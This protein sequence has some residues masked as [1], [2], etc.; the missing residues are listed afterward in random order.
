MVEATTEHIGLDMFGLD[1]LLTPKGKHF[2]LEVNSA[3]ILFQIT[4]RRLAKA[5]KRSIEN[6]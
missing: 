2:L 4:E 6:A 3:P 1:V 5:I